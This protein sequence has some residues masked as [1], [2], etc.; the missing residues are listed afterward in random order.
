MKLEDV[1]TIEQLTD[2]LS[3][4]EA[5]AIPVI[6]NKDERYRWI[7]GELVRFG[8]LTQ[9][10]HGKGVVIRYLIKITGYSR[11]QLNRLIAQYRQTGALR[12]R[13]RTVSGFKQK[14]TTQDIR[15]L[16]TLDQRYDTPCGP[17]VKSL[18]EQACEIF[19]Q[20]EYASLASISLS[21]MYNLRKSSIYARQR[22][23]LENT[24]P[25][26]F[27]IVARRKS[28]PNGRPGYIRIDAAHQ[29]DSEPRKA[30]PA[31]MPAAGNT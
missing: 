2:F 28:R 19:G 26:R 16:A 20:M 14:Y 29:L 25:E 17:V 18:C 10:R 6:S 3:G 22:Q 24:R 4:T 1:T 15:L 13:Q 12:R 5:A 9:S 30:F 23:Y 8:Y 31:S 27:S 11:Q 7:H 21:H